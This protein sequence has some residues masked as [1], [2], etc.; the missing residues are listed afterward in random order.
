MINRILLKIENI[1][2][3]RLEDI[4]DNGQCFRWKALE[5]NGNRNVSYIGVYNERVYIIKEIENLCFEDENLDKYKEKEKISLDVCVYLKE[6][7]K[8][9]EKLEKDILYNYL[10]LNRDYSKIKKEIIEKTKNTVGALDVKEAVEY[11]EGIRILKQDILETTISFIISAN[12][13]IPRIKKSVEYISKNYGEKIEIDDEIFGI[14]LNNFKENVYT[15]PKLERISALTEEDFKAAGTGFRAKRLV[16]TVRKLKEG[17]LEETESLSDEKLYEKL[18]NLDGVGPKVANCI[19]LFAYNRLD[20]FPIDVWVK[21][22]M[23]EIF[24]KDEEEKE[25]TNEKIMSIVSE[26]ENRGIM[27]QYLFYWRRERGKNGI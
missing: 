3:T 5:N 6:G 7:E 9:T 17:F 8:T 25:V 22:V 13:N 14:D 4:F 23:K 12:N 15:F 10:D 1:A 26:I 2:D 11:G 18:I 27:Q 21:R 16:E 24:F 19:M 20:S